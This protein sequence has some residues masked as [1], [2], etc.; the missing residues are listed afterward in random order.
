MGVQRFS[1]FIDDTQ[2]NNVRLRKEAYQKH[3]ATISIVLSIIL[4]FRC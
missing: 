1:Y 2:D 4:L 3:I